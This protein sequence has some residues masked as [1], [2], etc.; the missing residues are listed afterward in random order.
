MPVKA[1][2]DQSFIDVTVHQIDR[3]FEPS[4]G[5]KKFFNRELFDYAME[6]ATTDVERLRREFHAFA[7]DFG[8]EEWEIQVRAD[9]SLPAPKLHVKVLTPTARA[10]IVI[11][12]DRLEIIRDYT[13]PPKD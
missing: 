4:F 8:H 6:L 1:T 5:G 13:N 3:M 7:H 9:N 11:R 10:E 12:R 2:T